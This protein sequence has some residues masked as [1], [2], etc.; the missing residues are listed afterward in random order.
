MFI[1][2]DMPHIVKRMVYILESSSKKKNKR[3]SEYDGKVKS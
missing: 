3:K 1:G 2:G